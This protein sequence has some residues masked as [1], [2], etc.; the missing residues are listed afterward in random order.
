MKPLN[1]IIIERSYIIQKGLKK[2][3]EES[4]KF[5]I[6]DT[7][8]NNHQLENILSHHNIDIIFINNNT[9]NEFIK[10]LSK[11]NKIILI[12]L[13]NNSNFKPSDLFDD[14]I[15]IFAERSQIILKIE[16]IYKKLSTNEKSTTIELSNREK[17]ILR[18]VALGFTTKEIAE[19]LFLSPH[20]VVTHRKNI[21]N[22][23]GIKTVSGLTIYAV[24]N[25][26]ID[27]SEAK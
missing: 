12:T 6:I 25:N 10:T 7:I 8:F 21:S 17:T 23:L 14:F 18:Y 16:D 9:V 4:G 13:V 11:H 2:I 1:S 3:I 5:N 24:L 15:N 20:T 26:I 27:L 19:E 22:R